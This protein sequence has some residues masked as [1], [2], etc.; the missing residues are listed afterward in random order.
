M[1]SGLSLVV[2]LSIGLAVF[3]PL[4]LLFADAPPHNLAEL[5]ALRARLTAPQLQ[6]A[7]LHS[8]QVALLACGLASGLAI[9]AALAVIRALPTLR[10]PVSLLGLLPLA[11]PPFLG[12][13]VL[14][15]VAD[16]YNASAGVALFGRIDVAGSDI[17]L[18]AVYA[19]HYFP[20]ILFC[21]MAGLDRI[22]RGFEESAESLGAGR[23]TVWGRVILPLATPGFAAGAGLMILR[24][25][26]DIGAPLVL[27][28]DTLLAPQLLQRLGENGL[29]DPQL[30]VIALALFVTTLIVS[31]LGWSALSPPLRDPRHADGAPVRRRGTFAALFATLPLLAL[32]PITLL[33]LVGLTLLPLIGPSDTGPLGVAAAPTVQ[34][35]LVTAIGGAA[36]NT[37]WYAAGTGLLVMFGGLAAGIAAADRQWGGRLARFTI[38]AMF[39][40]P[41]V[42]L[43]L[44]YLHL[45]DWLLGPG[46][47]GPAL[48]WTSLALV[49]TFK[50]LPLA[51]RVL[52][53]PVR[54]LRGALDAA[55]ALGVAGPRL[56]LGTAGAG[57][58]GDLL[59]LFLVGAVA[60]AL[61]L[62]VA[63]VLISGTEAPYVANLFHAVRAAGSA[64][65]WAGWGTSLV[66]SVAI[67]L[68]VAL[69]LVRRRYRTS[70][71][72]PPRRNQP[73]RGDT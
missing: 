29:G 31:A 27:G 45:G 68:G 69:V 56:S 53:E 30:Q 18:S 2:L 61:E 64:A 54:Q 60:A 67:P 17:A 21:L 59:A 36:G 62:S 26:E 55:P 28:V 38:T 73:Q 57:L 65:P 33:P 1:S 49:V 35:D 66:I 46:P 24:I 15:R 13:A 48:A 22:D 7:L 16:L 25:V 63:L 9:P 11:M 50:L 70:P 12:A 19:L 23:L 6:Q 32:A 10:W 8:V 5:D 47:H 52:A 51:Q 3:L 58:A 44:G 39:A 34:P 41:G 42:V 71:R 72:R 4:V 20:F 37:F 43:A 40:V 14:D